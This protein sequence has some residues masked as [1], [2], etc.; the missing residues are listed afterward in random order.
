MNKKSIIDHISND[1]KL[2]KNV[3]IKPWKQL[4]SG[5]SKVLNHEKHVNVITEPSPVDRQGN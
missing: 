1:V 4:N 3:T 2:T 5:I